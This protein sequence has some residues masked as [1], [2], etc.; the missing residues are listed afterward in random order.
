[1]LFRSSRVVA[2]VVALAAVMG[3]LA[4]PREAHALE[5]R[6][7]H[8]VTTG[9]GHGFQTYDE[10]KHRITTFFERPY[11]FI[12]PAV[13]PALPPEREGVLRRNLAFD[14]FFGVKGGGG[15][16]WLSDD[17]GAESAEYVDQSNIIRVPANV[18]GTKADSFYFSPFGLEHNVMVGLLHAPGASDGYALF[19][20]HMGSGRPDPDAS[21]ESMRAV[22]GVPK[23][24]VERGP[25][26]GAMIYVPIGGVDHADC[27]GVF[28][29]GKGGQDL[30]DKADCTG[31]DLT[32]GFQK[33]EHRKPNADRRCPNRR[34]GK[35]AERQG[36]A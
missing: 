25:G 27:Q 13:T 17:A 33:K 26:G 18:G 20:F 30:A 6:T 5:K 4:V 36:R 31:N 32:A 1:M 10:G 24:I 29:K 12:A 14:V 9:N 16:G 35:I 21:G 2:G 7:W 22:A 28:D 11:R 8:F 15:G 23:S 19:N 34:P 3:I